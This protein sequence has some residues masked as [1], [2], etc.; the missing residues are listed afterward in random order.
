MISRLIS[1][2]RACFSLFILCI[3]F[4]C[5][6]FSQ[7][8]P[9]VLALDIQRELQ[10]SNTGLPLIASATILGS[11]L[12]QLPSGML[13]DKLGGKATLIIM[14]LIMGAGCMA[15]TFSS[16]IGGAAFGRFVT[17]LGNAYTVS[18]LA[19]CSLWFSRESY[20]RASSIL[21]TCGFLG[22]SAAL[23]P[24]ALA[25]EAFGW[26]ACA[27]GLGVFTF[28]LAAAAFVVIPK[29]VSSARA[30]SG[31]RIDFA[32]SLRIILA[33]RNF[34][35]FMLWFLMVPSVSLTLKSMWWASYLVK[36][37]GMEPQA[38]ANMLTAATLILLP[39][40]P[41]TG[42]L[43][44]RL[45][46]GRKPIVVATCLG[47]V[48]TLPL[49]MLLGRSDSVILHLMVS[50]PFIICVTVSMPILY[51]ATNETFPHEVLGT[52]MALL[53]EVNLLGVVLAQQAFGFIMDAALARGCDN[54]GAF[55]WGML[56]LE[57]MLVLALIGM[58]R[59]KET[60][61]SSPRPITD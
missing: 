20:G 14:L 38:A 9:N 27:G 52:A 42:W 6:L 39:A 54:T 47:A 15:F 34:R 41:L 43:S 3:A 49:I 28:L 17:G 19:L 8:L 7:T 36:S 24:L 57:A 23:G 61:G 44:D 30:A 25:N 18:M 11:A 13:T 22:V 51:A 45:L 16:G 4:G 29:D 37:C 58:A 48:V 21:V 26:R 46:K 1:R 10:L 33:N 5:L 12:M 50:I 32:Q 59:M 60:Y 53:T 56:L 2:P 40:T 35:L 31:P 55:R